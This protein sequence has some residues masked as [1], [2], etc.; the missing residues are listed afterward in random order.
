MRTVV[1]SRRFIFGPIGALRAPNLFLDLKAIAYHTQDLTSIRAASARVVRTVYPCLK[2]CRE[3][4]QFGNSGRGF[5][6]SSP[7]NPCGARFIFKPSG[8][9]RKV[10]LAIL[11]WVGAPLI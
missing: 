4:S 1:Y 9:G 10:R 3:G 11:G 7:G 2:P 5:R 6:F 8:A